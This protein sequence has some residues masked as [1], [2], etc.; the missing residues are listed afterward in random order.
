MDSYTPF[1]EKMIHDGINCGG[2]GSAGLST[3]SV[4]EKMAYSSQSAK[5]H[6]SFTKTSPE[7]LVIYIR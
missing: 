7:E 1:F 3:N 5:S 6:F 2:Q 4:Y